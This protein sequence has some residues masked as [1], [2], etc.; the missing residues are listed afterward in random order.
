ME[1]L[2]FRTGSSR[3]AVDVSSVL[4]ILDDA[5]VVA[6]PELP[7]FLPGVIDHR[8]T[9]L[10]VVDFRALSGT[11]P[12]AR[13]ATIVVSGSEGAPLAMVVDVVESTTTLEV[14]KPDDEERRSWVVGRGGDVAIVDPAA[15]LE[16]RR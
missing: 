14:S 9:L 16:V 12:A 1:A 10:P 11:C 2:L 4:E 5:A 13:G 8:G 3:W 15:M 6:L 7:P